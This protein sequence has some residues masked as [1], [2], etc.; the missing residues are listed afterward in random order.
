MRCRRAEKLLSDDLDGT[1]GPA[2]KARLGSHLGACPACRAYRDRLALLRKALGAPVERPDPYWAGFETRLAARLDKGEEGPGRLAGRAPLPGRR[3]LAWASAAV[4]AL[5]VLAAAWLAFLRPRPAVLAAWTA[6]DDPF[7]PLY[8]ATEADP[9][10]ARAVD[11]EIRASIDELV[12]APD[13][14][15]A[16]LRAADP[17]FWEGLSETELDAIAEALERENGLGGPR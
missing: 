6:G 10:L 12:N 9:E 2:R 5:A 16:A 3:R 11:Q 14:D 13:A 15:A 1:L 8:F 7:A 17:L 4:S